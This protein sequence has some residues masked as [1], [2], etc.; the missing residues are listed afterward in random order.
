MARA[1]SSTGIDEL[2]VA[3]RAY[4]LRETQDGEDERDAGPRT[5]G[6]GRRV[7]EHFLIFDTE[8][9]VDE[10]QRLLFGGWRYYRSVPANP[11]VKLVWV[12]EGL[13]YPDDLAERDPDGF[14][15]LRS[16][17]GRSLDTDPSQLDA[18]RRLRVVSQTQFLNSIVWRAA[19][20]ARAALVCFNWP[21][22]VSRLARHAGEAR[23]KSG[24]PTIVDGGF[25]LLLWPYDLN[26]QRKQSRYRP[27]IAIK[28]IDSKRAFKRFKGPDRIDFVD[29]IPEG[30]H[31]PDED[32]KF[33]GNFLDLR[34]L[35]FALTDRGYSLESGCEAFGVPYEKRE[36]EL[37]V[38]TPEAV[39]YCR[40]DVEATSRLCEATV[41]EF[42]R[43]PIKLQA[44]RAYSPATLGRSYL[45]AMRVTPPSQRQDFDPH[46]FGWA[47]SAY[48][49]GR[50]ECRIRKHAVPVVYLDFLSMYPTVCRLLGVWQQLTAKHVEVDDQDPAET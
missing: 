41:N 1:E 27:S 45:R 21:F 5:G 39:E 29:R 43:H 26:G 12:S 11:G 30:E 31:E 22:D 15:V 8:T 35:T 44:A 17:D 40:E 42:L 2:D 32:W 18:N 48:Y 6:G 13:F 34:T 37:G 9:T 19:Y 10:T 47:M 25:S 14:A 4:A 24:Q 23:N 50:A 3:V 36:V 33:R 16:F 46:L 7:P 28:S 49:G 20:Q 38:I